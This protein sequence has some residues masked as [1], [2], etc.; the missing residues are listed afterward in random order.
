MT[1]SLDPFILA[2]MMNHS[3]VQRAASLLSVVFLLFAIVRLGFFWKTETANQVLVGLLIFGVCAALFAG[4]KHTVVIHIIPTLYGFAT[5]ECVNTVRVLWPSVLPQK[6]F[7]GMVLGTTESAGLVSFLG[8]TALV[9]G[10][11]YTVSDLLM[12]VCA[13]VTVPR[14]WSVVQR[15]PLLFVLI[16]SFVLTSIYSIDLVLRHAAFAAT[17]YDFGIFDQAL[18]MLSRGA[19]SSTTRQFTNIFFDHQ[20]FSLLL[21]APLYWIGRGFHGYALQIIT[22]FLLIFFP[23]VV[24]FFIVEKFARIRKI[25]LPAPYWV[26]PITTV[27][28]WLHPYTQS[29]IG[30]YFHEKYLMPLVFTG[31]LYAVVSYVHT[32][33]WRWF[34]A[35]CALALVRL[36]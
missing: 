33:M 30:F 18:Y 14:W 27:V 6:Q 7:L 9:L 25:D 13:S 1:L 16:F 17:V 32:P 4:K 20:H 22:P 31:F 5:L 34:V 21:L 12:Q 2:D 26:I 36:S 11:S 29:A 35:M 28:L 15:R 19:T 10:V 24:T 23:S 8:V 3:F